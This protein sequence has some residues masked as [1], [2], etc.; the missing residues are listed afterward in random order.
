[1]TKLTEQADGTLLAP[2][3][4]QLCAE[5]LKAWRDYAAKPGHRL[6]ET[7]DPPLSIEAARAIL[8]GQSP[9]YK[10]ASNAEIAQSESSLNK[11][12]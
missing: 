4:N 1:M 10:C 12:Q 7:L 2:S 8:E 3:F 5:L 9:H 6:T 11:Y